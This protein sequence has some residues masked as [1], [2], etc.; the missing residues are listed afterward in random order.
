ME[1]LPGLVR[2]YRNAEAKGA[3][4]A[5]VKSAFWEIYLPKSLAE[6]ELSEVRASGFTMTNSSVSPYDVRR[7]GS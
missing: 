3:D 6:E 1:K 4:L 5:L 7:A 2:G